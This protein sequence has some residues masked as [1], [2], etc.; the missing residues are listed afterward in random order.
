MVAVRR[1][2]VEVVQR[3]E[4]RRPAPAAR[5]T[6]AQRVELGV[7]VEVVG[8]LVEQEQLGLLRQGAGQVDPLALAAG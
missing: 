1:G 7:D 6:E 8:R 2:E 4:R 3:D 5:R